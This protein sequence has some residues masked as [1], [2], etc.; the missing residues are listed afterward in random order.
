MANVYRQRMRQH[1]EGGQLGGDGGSL[2][3][4]QHQW[5]QHNQQST[6]S[7]G[8]YCDGNGND[9]SDNNNDKNKG[10]GSG[11]GTFGAARRRAR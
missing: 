1:T 6:K 3:S 11:G 8:G 9:D 2:V 4:A 10:D 7:V 5:R